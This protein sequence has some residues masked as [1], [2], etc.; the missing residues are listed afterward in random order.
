RADVRVGQRVEKKQVIGL[1]GNEGNS[2]GPHL[3]LE[4]RVEKDAWDGN[5]NYKLV[6]TKPNGKPLYDGPYTDDP[7][8]YLEGIAD[9]IK[10]GA[11]IC[12]PDLEDRLDGLGRD[13]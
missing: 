6:G 2:T 12:D 4:I 7:E 10:P 3:H 8:I 9:E 13:L 5:L 1:S 11:I